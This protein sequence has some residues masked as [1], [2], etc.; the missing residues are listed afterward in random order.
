MQTLLWVALGSG[1]GGAG[2]YLLVTYAE[3]LT[4][5][6]FPWG[7]LLVNVI[8]SLIIGYY[9]AAM[10][11]SGRLLESSIERQFIMFG[12]LGGF[13]TFSAF[14]LQTLQLIQSGN[15][16]AATLNIIASVAICLVSVWLGHTVGTLVH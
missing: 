13:T 8:G 12:I 9:V 6:E 2:R 10:I 5:G 1:I 7:T 11:S 3:K 4:T 15:L 16:G 14:S